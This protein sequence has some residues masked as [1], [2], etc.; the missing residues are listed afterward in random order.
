MGKGG[1][2]EWAG[3]GGGGG[4]GGGGAGTC[5]PYR[6]HPSPP[7]CNLSLSLQRAWRLT[8]HAAIVFTASPKCE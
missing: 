1:G 6:W 8:D 7:A 3:E 2:V 4:G 5:G